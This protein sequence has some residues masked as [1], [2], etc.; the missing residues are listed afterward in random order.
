MTSPVLI[1]MLHSHWNL[2]PTVSYSFELVPK[3]MS[4]HHCHP[5]MTA[6]IRVFQNHPAIAMAE[7]DL[8][9]SYSEIFV[10][11]FDFLGSI[12]LPPKNHLCQFLKRDKLSKQEP[13]FY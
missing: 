1:P 3:P 13:L 6:P 10:S 2:N 5:N 4:Y 12:S 7:Y 8:E 9:N 11:D